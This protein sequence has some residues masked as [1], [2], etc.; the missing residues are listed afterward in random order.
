MI[1][2]KSWRRVH[3]NCEYRLPLL[4]SVA[5]DASDYRFCQRDNEGGFCNG[6]LGSFGN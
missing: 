6:F 5:Q 4:A 2:L 1:S 3:E